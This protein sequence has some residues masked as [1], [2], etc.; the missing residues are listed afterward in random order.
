MEYLLFLMEVTLIQEYHHKLVFLILLVRKYLD[1]EVILE[2]LAK[3]MLLM[4][5]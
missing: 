4:L 1:T 2:E 3:M 5:I